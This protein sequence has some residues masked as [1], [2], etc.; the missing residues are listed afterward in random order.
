VREEQFAVQWLGLAAVVSMPAEI[1]MANANAI[2]DGLLAALDKGP[3]VLIADM[4]ATT[5]CDSAGVRALVQVS[6]Q[7]KTAGVALRLALTARGVLRVLSISGAATL[8][9]IYSSVAAAAGAPQSAS[10]EQ[11]GQASP[12]QAE[13]TAGPGEPEPTAP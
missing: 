3:P 10:P 13:T 6:R 11:P 9:E 2:R 8:L 4:T 5:F 1:D 12:L 7:T